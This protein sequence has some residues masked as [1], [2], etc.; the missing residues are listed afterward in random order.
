MRNQADVY[1]HSTIIKRWDVCYCDFF[2]HSLDKY[3]KINLIKVCAPNAIL[4]NLG[5]RLTKLDGQRV[6][7]ADADS[8]VIN[9]IL[10]SLHYYDYFFKVF[11]Q[12]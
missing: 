8:N 1:L 3:S 2:I 7:Y 6:S 10:A 4:N 12:N 9:G 5:G 11:K